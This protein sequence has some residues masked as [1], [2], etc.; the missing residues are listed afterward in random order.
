MALVCS[1]ALWANAAEPDIGLLRVGGE[2]H[3]LGDVVRDRR[4]PLEAVGRDGPDVQ[5]Q[6]QVGDRRREVGVAGPL[7]VAVDAALDVGRA[8]PDRGERVGHRTARVVVEVH[9]DLALEVGHHAGH[10]AL[11]V[12]GQ[13]PAVG[14]AEH[15]GLG[16]GLLGGPQHPQ[17]R[18]RGSSR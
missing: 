14:V 16:A 3:E 18:T 8:G 1:P 2:V 10:D 6:R 12:V 7:A 13:G 4:E 5:L 15:E 11:D 17:A 9:P